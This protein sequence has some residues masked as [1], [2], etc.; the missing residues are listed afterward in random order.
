MSR[1]ATAVMERGY[2]TD[3]TPDVGPACEAVV[4]LTLSYVVAPAAADEEA[5]LQVARTVRGLLP[6][7]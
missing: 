7:G 3:D 4:R 6:A 5:C 2:R 1:R